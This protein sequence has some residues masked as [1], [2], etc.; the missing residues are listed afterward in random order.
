MF[1]KEEAITSYLLQDDFEKPENIGDL[2]VSSVTEVDY[3]R[4]F[5][6]DCRDSQVH[7]LLNSTSGVDKSNHTTGVPANP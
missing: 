2:G 1:D 7:E 6:V 5:N 3:Y 4:P